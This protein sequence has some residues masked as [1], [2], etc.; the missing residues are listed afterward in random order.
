MVYN[1]LRRIVDA[2]RVS[3][4]I[5]DRI[6]SSY[7]ASRIKYLPDVVVKIITTKEVSEIL[8][9]AYTEKVPVYTRGAGS[10][11]TGSAVPVKGG[12]L[13]DTSLMNR[14]VEISPVDLTAVVE[15]GV[16]VTDFQKEVEKYNLFYPPDPASADFC[17]IGGNVATGAGGLRCIKYGTTRDYVLG[18]EVVLSDGRIIN[19]GGGTLKKVSGYDLTRLMVGS[20][21]TLGIFTRIILRLI[22]K[23]TAESTIS[24]FFD[25]PD[26]AIEFGV[27]LLEKGILPRSLEFMDRACL[28]AVNKYRPDLKIPPTSQAMILV[29][30]DGQPEDVNNQA[31]QS[32]KLLEGIQP[33]TLKRAV[34][35]E[36]AKYLW[37]VRKAISAALY[38]ITT[39]KISEDICVPRHAIKPI[40]SY[41]NEIGASSGIPVAVFGHLGD[42]NLHINFLVSNP[43]DRA[44]GTSKEQEARLAGVLDKLFTK[45]IKLGG[46]LSGEH[47]I[48]MTKAKYLPLEWGRDEI[49]LFRAIKQL[50]DPKN[51]LN[52]DKIFS[53]YDVWV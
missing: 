49:E 27:L 8:K 10:S 37:S 1:R 25:T 35:K 42:G 9:I 5:E 26:K 53:Q 2:S 17:T 28:M 46:T 20:E 19:T 11:V 15:P 32:C 50:F 12:I 23:P 47:G 6:V 16:V 30:F 39:Q 22:P 43:S 4:A 40:L 33:I 44:F 48:G 52:P 3:D 21:G 13:L 41:L 34:N 29:E 51:I 31:T 24:A 38:S 7:D 45:T 18:L 36:E 14:I